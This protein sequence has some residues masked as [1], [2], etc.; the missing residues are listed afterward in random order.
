MRLILTSFL[1]IFT[2]N[3]YSQN[4]TKSGD[5]QVL[6]SSNVISCFVEGDSY[7]YVKLPEGGLTL[8]RYQASDIIAH[9]DQFSEFVKKAAETKFSYNNRILSTASTATYPLGVKIVIVGQSNTDGKA[10]LGIRIVLPGVSYHYGES[11]T[12]WLDSDGAIAFKKMLVDGF[13]IDA[14]LATK[15]EIMQ[16]AATG[17]Q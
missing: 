3:L 16:K 12:Y 14:D 2:I 15:L 9:I 4:T 7:L 5:V 1:L 6:G 10:Y 17:N 11:T 8:S 13:T